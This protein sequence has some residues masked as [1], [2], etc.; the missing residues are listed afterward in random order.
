V[1]ASSSLYFAHST[2]RFS[3]SDIPCKFFSG[4]SSK[5]PLLLGELAMGLEEMGLDDSGEEDCGVEDSEECS[6]EE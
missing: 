1:I 5:S 2:N 3:M 6:V 4:L